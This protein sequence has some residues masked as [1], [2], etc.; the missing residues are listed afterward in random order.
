LFKKMLLTS[1]SFLLA[2]LLT[3]AAVTAA[4]TEEHTLAADVN[5]RAAGNNDNDMDWGWIG[6]AGLLGLV[7]LRNRSD[8]TSRNR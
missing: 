1:F 5:T 6:L 4:G 8:N 3:S 7:G 2:F